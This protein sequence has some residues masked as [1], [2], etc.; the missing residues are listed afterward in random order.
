MSTSLTIKDDVS[1]PFNYDGMLSDLYTL[2]H[3]KN[4]ELTD[5]HRKKIRPPEVMRVGSTRTAW[6]NFKD[7]CIRYAACFHLYETFGRLAHILSVCSMKREKD[8]V[9]SFF[10]A[11]LGTTG[12]IDGSERFLMRGRYLPKAIENLLR[13]YIQEYVTCHMCKSLET[14]LARDAV[15]RLYFL[16]CKACGSQRSVA[17][18]KAG[19]H[20]TSKGDRKKA[21]EAA[22]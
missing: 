20:A 15:S 11:E 13:R 19:F 9:L 18:I 1:S 22:S 4:P 3:E 17:P 6:I 12:S 5:R 21:R 14:E 8:H 7:N 10:L 16:S 2:L